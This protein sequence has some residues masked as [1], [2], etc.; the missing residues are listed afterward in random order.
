MCASV[1]VI[2]RKFPVL[3]LYML[4]SSSPRHGLAATGSVSRCNVRTS[5]PV[6]AHTKGCSGSLTRV[7]AH[8]SLLNLSHLEMGTSQVCFIHPLVLI[9]WQ[10]VCALQML[11]SNRQ[12]YP[13]P[14]LSMS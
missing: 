6:M 9:S 10:L 1:R 13:E 14:T 8:G 12:S 5:P 2:S 3:V 11:A 7:P 4:A